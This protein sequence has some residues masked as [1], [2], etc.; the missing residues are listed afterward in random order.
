MAGSPVDPDTNFKVK[1][2]VC[3]GY[4]YAATQPTT[5]NS[6]GKKIRKY[7]YWGEV[8][9]D[10]VFV[11][12]LR[13]K[14]EPLSSR[15]KLIFPDEWDISEAVRLNENAK[16]GSA[17]V[18]KDDRGSEQFE[19]RQY[20]A[21]WLLEKLAEQCHIKDD[22]MDV[23][24]YDETIVNDV[25]TLAIFPMLSGWSYAQTAR[26]QKYTKT[27][28]DHFLQPSYITRLTQRITNQHRME[29]LHARILREK[30][31]ALLACDSTTRSGY[32]HCLADIRW[33]KNKDNSAMMNTLEVV[34]YSITSHEPIY[35]RTFAG[36]EN[37]KRTVRAI[38]A[39]LKE[40]GIDDL[41][42]IFDRGYESDDNFVEMIEDD[43]PF[44]MCGIVSREPIYSNILKIRYNKRGI[45][46][47]MK[48]DK[49]NHCYYAQFSQPYRVDGKEAELKVNLYMDIERRAKELS[50]LNEAIR[51]EEEKIKNKI[52]S[53]KSFDID[54][55]NNSLDYH[56]VLEDMSYIQKEKAIAREENIAGFFA[57]IQF[58]LNTGAKE[59]MEFYGLRDEQEKYFEEMKD[60]LGFNMQNNWSED[61][62]TGRLFILFIGL[63]LRNK[64]RSVWKEKLKSQG[65]PS[66]VDVL[67]DMVPIRMNEYPDGN[68][69]ITD[70][71]TSQMTICEAFG[72]E[73]PKE[74]LSSYQKE[75]HERRKAGRKR[76]RPKGS[77]NKKKKS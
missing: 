56:K 44:L 39:D 54:Q 76:G 8:T 16:N 58:K 70:F 49:A 18:K 5:I 3:R 50:I 62:K 10:L 48:Y 28:S 2:R 61:G 52:S 27:P 71:T 36:N 23:F 77:I 12:N 37:D 55:F 9:E 75:V 43:Q 19:N 59:S 45:P 13:F 7:V 31:N 72:I 29:F 24:Q 11:P 33:G 64:V 26:W 6:S 46:E 51:D 42:I 63:I 41:T 15:E 60:Q 22:L 17:D 14:T 68:I 67:H 35:Y 47:N 66:S 65:Y 57:S 40:L 69:L 32:E 73:P 34:V 53:G 30:P 20:G 25:L 38:M 1:L 4:R 74:C 21:V